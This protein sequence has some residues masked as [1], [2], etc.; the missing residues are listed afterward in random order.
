MSDIL[1]RINNMK[2]RN[3]FNK[4]FHRQALE[5]QEAK[6]V[7]SKNLV[8]MS[9][10]IQVK[11]DGCQTLIELLHVHKELWDKGF[12]NF[13]LGPCQWGMFR[14]HDISKMHPSEVFL[15]GIWGLTTRNIPFWEVYSDEDMSGNGFGLDDSTKIYDLIM[16]QYRRL[17]QLN[18]EDIT[19]KAQLYI[20]E[21]EM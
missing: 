19:H 7:D 5:E 1:S 12:Q 17:L 11:I 18:V 8:Q 6:Y 9:Y 16:N 21:Y 3:L 14:T 20:K 4:V 10:D 15:G 2:K 13:N